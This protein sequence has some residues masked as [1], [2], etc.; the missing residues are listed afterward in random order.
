MKLKSF[1][2]TAFAALAVLI[3]ALATV[4]QARAQEGDIEV[5]SGQGEE[6][7]IKHNLFGRQNLVLQD[8]LGNKIERQTGLLGDSKANVQVLGNGYEAKKGVWGNKS[9][10]VS[11]VLGDKVE[12]KRSWF[13]LGR[14]KTT[15]DLSGTVGLV[16]QVL[17]TKAS[18]DKADVH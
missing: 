14:R 15:V 16:N 9:Y 6:F 3:S 18:K 4:E 5:K 13:G 11:T 12:T 10:K 8:R 1:K 7:N 2:Y 17:K